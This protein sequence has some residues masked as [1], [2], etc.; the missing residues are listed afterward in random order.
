M[1]QYLCSSDGRYRFGLDPN[2]NLELRAS[3]GVLWSA[4]ISSGYQ[5]W[6]QRDGNLVVNA[7]SG[8]PLFSSRTAGSDGAF[9]SVE[10][11]ARAV[12]WRAGQVIWSTSQP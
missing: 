1:G 4:R 7:L 6:M 5:L 3:E 12:L 10:D 8:A 11:D 2:G 9:L